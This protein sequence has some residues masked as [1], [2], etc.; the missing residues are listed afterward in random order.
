MARIFTIALLFSINSH[1]LERRTAFIDNKNLISSGISPTLKLQPR[2][3]GM[4][5]CC[6]T[7]LIYLAIIAHQRA[8][9]RH[10]ICMFRVIINPFERVIDR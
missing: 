10:G 6:H 2:I 4:T 3:I 5:N 9:G 8:T 1:F 7:C